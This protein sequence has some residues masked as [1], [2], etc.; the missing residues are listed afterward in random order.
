MKQDKKYKYKVVQWSPHK[1]DNLE[2]A[3]AKFYVS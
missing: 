1:S 3:R 2:L